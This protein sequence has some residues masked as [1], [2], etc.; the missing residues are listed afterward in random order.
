MTDITSIIVKKLLSQN[1]DINTIS[2]VSELSHEEIM[3][4]QLN[5]KVD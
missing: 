2:Q 4:I 3:T 5:M 1:I